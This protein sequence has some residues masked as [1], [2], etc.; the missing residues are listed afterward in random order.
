MAND[1]IT[2]ETR[3]HGNL[4]RVLSLA[5][6]G[7]VFL[8]GIGFGLAGYAADLKDAKAAAA[9]ANELIGKVAETQAQLAETQKLQAKDIQQLTT[10]AARSQAELEKQNDRQ[11]RQLALI[12]EEIRRR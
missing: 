12:L 9:K 10:Q 5:G 8:T 7:A 2:E 1:A 11:E 4:W 6:V 3:V